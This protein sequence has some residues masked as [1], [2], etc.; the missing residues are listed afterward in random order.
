MIGYGCTADP[1]YDPD[2]RCPHDEGFHHGIDVA[3][4]CGTPL[5]AGLPGVVVA[6]RSAGALGPAYGPYAFRIRTRGTDPVDI[7]IG[8]VLKV[9]VDPGQHVRR[10]QL[11]ARANDQGAPDGCHLHFEVRP[12]AADYTRAM[13]PAHYLRLR[14][15]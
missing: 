12:A 6:A 1:Y 11:I 2:P 10:G 13:D 4:P 5:Y 9:Y 7:V 15:G 8:H 3:M 14:Q